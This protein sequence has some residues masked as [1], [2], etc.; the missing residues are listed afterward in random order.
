MIFSLPVF[1]F[2]CRQVQLV[3]ESFGQLVQHAP[4][5]IRVQIPA[6][7]GVSPEDLVHSNLVP[8]G[9]RFYAFPVPRYF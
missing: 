4:Y 2:D 6:E 9:K 7:V 1:Y 3:F 5:L 8:D